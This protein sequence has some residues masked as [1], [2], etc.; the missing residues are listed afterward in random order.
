[1]CFSII[2]NFIESLNNIDAAENVIKILV[3]NKLDW[4]E[5]R[6]ISF[7]EGQ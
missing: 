4:A 7:E 2:E 6:V 5:Q 3:G 1:M